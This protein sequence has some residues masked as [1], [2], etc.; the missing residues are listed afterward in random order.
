MTWKKINSKVDLK[1]RINFFVDVND[2]QGKNIE[3]IKSQA[4]DLA[5]KVTLF[6]RDVEMAPMSS[7]ERMIVHSVLEDNPNVFTES[8]GE[9][10]F[11]R[12]VIKTK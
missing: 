11:R 9:N 8:I 10:G 6:K 2:Y 4:L 3:R 12:L 7:Y 5:E 1:E